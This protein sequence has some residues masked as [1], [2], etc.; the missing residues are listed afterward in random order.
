[1]LCEEEGYSLIID[2]SSNNPYT[3]TLCELNEHVTVHT[4]SSTC[5]FNHS[6][7]FTASNHI[8]DFY[9]KDKPSLEYK[10]QKGSNI[11]S[12]VLDNQST[13]QLRTDIKRYK[14]RDKLNLLDE[15]YY[16]DLN[17]YTKNR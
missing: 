16:K 13:S 8:E 6:K 9:D 7:E 2:Y 14:L 4:Y 5:S 10:T 11:T 15:S 17:R 1:M 12:S 3:L